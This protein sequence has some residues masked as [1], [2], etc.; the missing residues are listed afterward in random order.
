MCIARFLASV[1]H[2]RAVAMSTR[3]RRKRAVF[4]YGVCFGVPGLVM[5]THILYQASRYGLTIG[6]GCYA[7]NATTWPFVALY[8]I[9]PPIFAVIATLYACESHSRHSHAALTIT[10]QCM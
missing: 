4:D 2:P 6:L 5:A 7:D 1:V 8:A 9:W 3:E 10:P